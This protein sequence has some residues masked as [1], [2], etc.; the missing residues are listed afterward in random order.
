VPVDDGLG[1]N[2]D[3]M[4]AP[5]VPDQPEQDPEELVAGTE[6]DSLPGR[7]TQDGELLPQEE[8][9]GD[10]IGAAAEESLERGCE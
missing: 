2:H 8:V 5:V 4:R 3:E 6:A 1:S 7:T 9:L 10:Q